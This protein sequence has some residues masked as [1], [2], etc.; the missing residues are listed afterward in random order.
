MF[1]TAEVINGSQIQEGHEII[2]ENALYNLVKKLSCIIKEKRKTH[3]SDQMNTEW[4]KIALIIPLLEE[5]GWDKSTDVEYE[6]GP[7]T[8]EGRIDLILNCRT[9]VGIETRPLHESPPQNIEHPQIKNGLRLCKAKKAPYF[10]WTNG[11]SWQFFSL[12]FTNAP[13]YHVCLSDMD[14]DTSSMEQLLIIKKD[15]F[16]SHPEKFNK[17]VNENSKIAALP[18]AWMAVLRDHTRELIQV[19]RKGLQNAD[20]KDEMIVKFLKTL[21]SEDLLSQARSP[22]WVPKPR[23]WEQLIDSYDSPYRLARWFFRTSYYRKLG[24]YLINEN[25]KPWPKDSTWR[26]VGLPD[27]LNERKKV[28]HAVFM[29]REWGFIEEAVDGKYYRVEE[30]VPYLEKLLERTTSP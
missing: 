23:N 3:Q 26:H 22:V 24:E 6:F 13:F 10:I 16:I 14:N 1:L 30:C 19:F 4:T 21:G 9:P 25:Y 17:A 29:F 5:L 27:G 11:D 20:I 18:H 2:R 15:V 28:G 8:S 12:A 7:I